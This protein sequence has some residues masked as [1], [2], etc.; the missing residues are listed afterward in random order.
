[1]TLD[2]YIGITRLERNKER[3]RDFKEIICK[4]EMDLEAY[5]PV[6]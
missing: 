2:Y 5:I 1:M 3:E 4:H 6:V